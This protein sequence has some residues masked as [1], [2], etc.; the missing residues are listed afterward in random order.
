M[1]TCYMTQGI[2]SNQGLITTEKH[3]MGRDVQVGGD[4]GKPTADSC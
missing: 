1:A 2:Q 3:G 4:M